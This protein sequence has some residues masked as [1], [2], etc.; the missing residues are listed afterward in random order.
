MPR[1]KYYANPRVK[2]VCR[3]LRKELSPRGK[4][5]LSNE[6]G[7]TLTAIYDA[8]KGKTFR[9]DIWERAAEIIAENRMAE[10]R[11]EK[12]IEEILK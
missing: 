9:P 7:V 3:R 8:L 1:I 4:K 11:L 2:R 6:F 5:T 12:N 10:E